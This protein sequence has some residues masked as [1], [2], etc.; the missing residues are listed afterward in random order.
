MKRI[1]KILL[2][3]PLLAVVFYSCEE[4]E[5]SED[6]DVNFPAPVINSISKEEVFVGEEITVEGENLDLTS[7]FMLKIGRAHV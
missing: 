6:Y 2:L 4:E 3:L 7:K 5:W 1:S